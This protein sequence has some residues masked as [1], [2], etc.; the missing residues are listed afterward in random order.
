M[1]REIRCLLKEYEENLIKVGEDE[2]PKYSLL[3]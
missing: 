1:G 3:G 2:K